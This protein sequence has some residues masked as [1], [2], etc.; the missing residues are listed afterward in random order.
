VA[1]LVASSSGLFRSNLSTVRGRADFAFVDENRARLRRNAL[2][3]F[4][5][6]CEGSRRS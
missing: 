5:D 4:I 6:C 1:M 3:I 2:I